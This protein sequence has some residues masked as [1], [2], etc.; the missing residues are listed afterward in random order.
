[1]KVPNKL[2]DNYLKNEGN[3][4]KNNYQKKYTNRASEY[5]NSATG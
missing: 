1:M 3:C 5:T 2:L 4:R